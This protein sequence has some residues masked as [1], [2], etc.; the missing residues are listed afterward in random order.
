MNVKFYNT[1]RLKLCDKAA[2]MPR[3]VAIKAHIARA[4]AIERGF[5]ARLLVM[6]HLACHE[7][8]ILR[9][10]LLEER[11]QNLIAAPAAKER[12]V[13]L[14]RKRR[15]QRI[16]LCDIG[17]VRIRERNGRRKAR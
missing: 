4:K 16:A 11:E 8:H 10:R 6:P 7:A 13:R 5:H 14:E 15:F 12:L 9:P 17:Q 3:I 1:N 2:P